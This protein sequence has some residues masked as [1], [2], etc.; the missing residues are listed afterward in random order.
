[1]QAIIRSD[2]KII[3]EAVLRFLQSLNF[4]IAIDSVKKIHESKK[5]LTRGKYLPKE[6]SLNKLIGLYN[7]GINTG[8]IKHDQELYG[9]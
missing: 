5:N 9:S 2:N 4:D 1:M 7:S 8:S 6:N 3:F